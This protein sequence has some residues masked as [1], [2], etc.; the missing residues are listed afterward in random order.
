[1]KGILMTINLNIEK[2]NSLDGKEHTLDIDFDICDNCNT[3][4]AW[5]VYKK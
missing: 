2:E 3:F 4:Y 5:R 1:V